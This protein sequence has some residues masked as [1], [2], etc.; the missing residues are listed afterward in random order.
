MFFEVVELLACPHCGPAHGLVLLVEE[1]GERRV[2]SGQLGCPNCKRDY[3]VSEGV[4]DLR[5]GAPAE[6]TKASGPL[7]EEGLAVKIVALSGLTEGRGYVLID[8]RLA[9]AGA[10]V[11]DVLPGLEVITVRAAP[12]ESTERDGVSRLL[13]DVAFPVT[14][15]RLRA[16]AIAPGGDRD[17]VAAAARRVAPGGR[18]VLFDARS[19]DIEEAERSGLAIVA[20]EGSTAVAE[21]KV[22]PPAPSDLG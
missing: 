19:D 14:E 9:H 18:L 13:S 7:Q 10:E 20:R 6:S 2:H 1:M 22:A 5:I 11:A 17:R 3:P 16:V 4:A 8:E 15:Y 21:R 12:D